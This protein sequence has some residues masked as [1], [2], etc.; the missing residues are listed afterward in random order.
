MTNSQK[1]SLQTVLLIIVALAIGLIGGYFLSSKSAVVENTPDTTQA[2]STT[3]SGTVLA[4]YQNYANPTVGFSTLISNKGKVGD[5]KSDT[6]NWSFYEGVNPQFVYIYGPDPKTNIKSRIVV[7]Q[8]ERGACLPKLVTD[9]PNFVEP[10]Q[11]KANLT[12]LQ[13][14]WSDA[15]MGQYEDLA[16]YSIANG[17]KQYCVVGQMHGS[18]PYN[19]EG[20]AYEDQEKI[21]A[22]A[23]TEFMNVVKVFVDNFKF[24]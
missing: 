19:L 22:A 5:V 16:I 11:N 3:T 14:S 6:L 1:G 12:I 13:R 7:W 21:N 8:E 23:K 24:L 10:R 18:R 4:G 20:Q 2:V 15:A 9:E 17:K